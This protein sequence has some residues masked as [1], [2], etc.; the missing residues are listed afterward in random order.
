MAKN[1]RKK[2][3]PQKKSRFFSRKKIAL[4]LLSCICAF[5]IVYGVSYFEIMQSEKVTNKSTEVLMSKMK[6]MLDE[7]KKRLDSLPVYKKPKE[8]KKLPPLVIVT[9]KEVEKE[10]HLSEIKDYKDSLKK[11]K[12]EPK[13]PIHVEKKATYSGKPKLVIIIDDVAYAHQTRLMKKIPFKINPSFFPPTKRHPDTI[14]LSRDFKFAMIHLPTQAL[15]YASAEPQTLNVGDSIETI[16]E[17]IENIKKWFPSIKHYNNHTG[18]KFTS[19]FESMYKLM[20][21]LKEEQ[22]HFMDSRT[23]V[24]TKAP[25]VA[26]KLGMELYA[27]DIF[28][29]NSIE[30]KLIRKQLI[31]AVAIAKKRGYAIA[32]GHP[33][34]NTLNVLINAEDMLEG[35]ELVYLKE[36]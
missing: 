15:N 12:K 5:A 16:R 24:D 29:D 10:T 22:L 25:E 36:L 28:L 26:K 4:V 20:R 11:Q 1:R 18:S 6:K 31:K 19:D 3:K 32:I 8:T 27:R 23:T 33:H 2:R 17:R 34:K 7:E 21:V 30:K 35:V 13:K 14:K 9:P